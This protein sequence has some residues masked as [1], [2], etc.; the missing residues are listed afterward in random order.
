MTAVRYANG[1]ITIM[2]HG[3]LIYFD[4]SELVIDSRLALIRVAEDIIASDPAV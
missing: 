3:Q 4:L 2:Q 1:E